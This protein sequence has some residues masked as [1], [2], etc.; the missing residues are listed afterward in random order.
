MSRTV[1]NRP[2]SVVRRPRGYRQAVIA[3]VRPGARPPSANEDLQFDNQ[4]E[5]SAKYGKSKLFNY[6]QAL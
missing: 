2:F 5:V 1:K 6:K 4:C 3:G